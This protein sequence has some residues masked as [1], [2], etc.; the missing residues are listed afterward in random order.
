MNILDPT[1]LFDLI[2]AHVP[3]DLHQNILVV[4]SLAAAYHHRDKLGIDGVNT[5]DADVIV[6]PAGAIDQCREIAIRLLDEGWRR[7]DRCRPWPEN[8]PE[9]KLEAVRLYPPSSDAYFIELLGMPDR[10]Q[11]APKIMVPLPLPDGWYALPVFRYMGIVAVDRRVAES[12]LGYAA[13]EMMTLANLLAH[14]TLGTDRMTGL[15]GGRKL[16]RAAKDLGR[17]LALARLAEREDTEHWAESWDR[18]LRT[19]YS[20]EQ[21]NALAKRAGSGLRALLEDDAAFEEAHH[22]V[23][24]GLLSG[25]GVTLPQL[26]LVGAQLLADAIE[27]L[28]RS[29]GD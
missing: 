1:L 3:K 11:T 17:V 4:G 13:P 27:P 25:I 26:R 20:A 24:D 10:E 23:N 29:A 19:T 18:A 2:A 8:H 6:Q 14:P 21:A 9:E 12:G 22:A 16:L 15:I 7:V 5:K 28:E